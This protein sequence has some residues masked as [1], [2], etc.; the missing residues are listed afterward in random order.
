MAFNI[1]DLGGMKVKPIMNCHYIAA[2]RVRGKYWPLGIAPL[3]NVTGA[4]R[5]LVF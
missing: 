5:E 2:R 3:S 4:E 1:T